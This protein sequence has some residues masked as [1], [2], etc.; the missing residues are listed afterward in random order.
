[1]RRKRSNLNKFEQVW[2]SFVHK[3]EFYVSFY[4]ENEVA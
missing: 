2:T 3:L 4:R 1:M